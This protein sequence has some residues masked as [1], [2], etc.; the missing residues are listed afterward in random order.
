M[1]LR[2][3]LQLF[4]DITVAGAYIK[5]RT[6]VV[7]WESNTVKYVFGAWASREASKSGKPELPLGENQEIILSIPKGAETGSKA[8]QY[9]MIKFAVPFFSD[10]GDVLEETKP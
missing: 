2:K 10:A 3:D 4:G 7:E 5:I 1:G 6:T 9:N 8:D